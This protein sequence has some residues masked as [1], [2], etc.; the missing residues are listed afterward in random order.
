MALSPCMGMVGDPGD[1][2][3]QLCP[4]RAG[5]GALV[6]GRS[7]EMGRHIL[8]PELSICQER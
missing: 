5:W 7:L 8:V 6:M 1:K 2:V 4:D 3:V